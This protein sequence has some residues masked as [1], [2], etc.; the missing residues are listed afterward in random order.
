MCAA[1]RCSTLRATSLISE[2]NV[3]DVAIGESRVSTR[4]PSVSSSM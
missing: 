4:K 3:P 1:S 2:E